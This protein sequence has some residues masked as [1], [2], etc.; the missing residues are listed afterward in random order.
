MLDESGRAYSDDLHYQSL[1]RENDDVPP[2]VHEDNVVFFINMKLEGFT[3]RREGQ[4]AFGYSALCIPTSL[5]Q[6]PT[7]T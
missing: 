7:S 6:E 5:Q 4:G 1:E 3:S 2:A